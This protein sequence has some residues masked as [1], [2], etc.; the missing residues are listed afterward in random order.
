M[1]FNTC[2]N[3]KNSFKISLPSKARLPSILILDI[4]T[5]TKNNNKKTNHFINMFIVF[6]DE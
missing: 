4:V 1:F 6:Q 2:I 5:L 3:K